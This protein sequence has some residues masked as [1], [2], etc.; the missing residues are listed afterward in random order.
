M[1]FPHNAKLSFLFYFITKKFF[2]IV[3]LAFKTFKLLNESRIQ[4][5]H[6]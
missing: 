5:L 6:V 3:L 4:T 1:K 2:V